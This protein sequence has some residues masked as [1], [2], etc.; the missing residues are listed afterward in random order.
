M[1][2]E[3]RVQNAK[4]DSS[5]VSKMLNQNM[6]VRVYVFPERKNLTQSDKWQF[7]ALEIYSMRIKNDEE[8]SCKEVNVAK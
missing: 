6:Q 5:Q 8:K 4:S 7:F 3:K 1:K 2:G